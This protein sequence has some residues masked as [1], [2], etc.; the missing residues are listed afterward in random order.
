[1]RPYVYG[2]LRARENARRARVAAVERTTPTF[3]PAPPVDEPEVRGSSIGVKEYEVVRALAADKTGVVAADE[4][5]ISYHAFNTRVRKLYAIHNVSTRMD[6][7]MEWLRAGHLELDELALPAG[8]GAARLNEREALVVGLLRDGL[9]QKQVAQ[10]L[11]YTPVTVSTIVKRLKAR[12]D[13]A[14]VEGLVC[15][16]IRVGLVNIHREPMEGHPDAVEQQ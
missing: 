9:Q 4:L 8:R 13:M 1:M 3:L 6:V 11:G 2:A 16:A 7:I 12:W 10:R 14:T 15:A 5:G